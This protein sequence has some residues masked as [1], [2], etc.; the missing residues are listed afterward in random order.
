[1]A[2]YLG[3]PNYRNMWRDRGY[4]HADFENGCSDRLVDAMLAWGDEKTVWSRV[5]AHLDAGATHVPLV[6]INPDNPALICWKAI[7]A[8]APGGAYMNVFSAGI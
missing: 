1:M 5:H 6:P 3:L 4:T 7:E 8:F 2:L